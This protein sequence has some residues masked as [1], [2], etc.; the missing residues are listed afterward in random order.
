MR[1]ADLKQLIFDRF[2]ADLK[3]PLHVVSSPG[4]GKTQIMGQAAKELGIGFKMIHAPLM[5]PEDYGFP[6]ISADRKD[7]N[8]IVSKEKFPIEGSDC[9]ETGI[10]GIDELPQ[11]DNAGQKIFSQLLQ[12]REI[13]G[14]RL[15]AGWKIVSTGNRTTDRAGANRLLSHLRDRITEVELEASLDDWCDWAFNHNIQTEVIQFL[16]FRPDLL[17]HF[18]PQADK[19]PTPRSW[20]EGVS[21]DLGI[22]DRKVEH[23]VFTGSVGVG[24]ATEFVSFLQIYRD[25]PNP[26]AIM[27][28][29][30]TYEIPKKPAVLFALVGA[31]VNRTSGNNFETAMKYVSRMKPEF[32]VLFVKDVIRRKS[33][34]AD[35]QTFK[36]WASSDGAKIL[37]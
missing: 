6:V 17:S 11:A 2:R 15:K 28:N 16:R 8:F 25:L 34:V 24:A 3:R 23:S 37:T 9:P 20:C 18:D 33:E 27:L 35:T 4:L 14:Q 31:L 12:E 7:V 30:E 1:P 36:R 13:H 22:V 21:A 32:T 5:Q 29:P 10:L 26:D 19:S